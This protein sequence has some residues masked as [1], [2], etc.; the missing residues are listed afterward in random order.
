MPNFKCSTGINVE[1][2][3]CLFDYLQA[4]KRHWHCKK[5]LKN[6]E[7]YYYLTGTN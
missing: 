1:V 3:N 2:F 7:T 6:G 5:K 4:K